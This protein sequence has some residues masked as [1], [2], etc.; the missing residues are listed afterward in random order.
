[1]S[2]RPP[3]DYGVA[4]ILLG[5]AERVV[6]PHRSTPLR[7]AVRRFLVAS[8]L[9]RK[10]TKTRAAKEFAALKRGR[11]RRCRSRRPRC[12]RYVN[13]RDVVHLGA[14]LLPYVA[15]YG[16][17]PALS[18]SRSAQ[19]AAPVFLLHGT[20]DNVIP[21]IE[22]EHLAAGSARQAPVRLLLSGLISHADADR[23]ARVGDVMQL[24]AFWGDLLSR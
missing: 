10:S 8:A 15:A 24:A 1:M 19:A 22:S 20:D 3:H 14:R 13:D 9:D 2:V 11:R 17:D 4:V 6:P 23:P 5:V 7:D 18:V 12:L 21:A 16:G